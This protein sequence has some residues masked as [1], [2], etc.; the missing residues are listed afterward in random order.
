MPRENKA[1]F[2]KSLGR[3]VPAEWIAREVK[4]KIKLVKE[5]E[6][7]PIVD[8]HL[9]LR[10]KSENDCTLVKKGGPGLSPVSS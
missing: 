3:R 7:F 1:V 10:F 4:L 5:P 6:I 9:I 2:V 8:D